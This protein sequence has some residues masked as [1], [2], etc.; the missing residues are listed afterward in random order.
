MIPAAAVVAKS[1]LA[2]LAAGLKQ[3]GPVA[4]D[5]RMLAFER[6]V[7]TAAVVDIHLE[8]NSEIKYVKILPPCNFTSLPFG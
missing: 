8:K 6:Q 1:D 4:S 3:V 5:R 7:E 2:K